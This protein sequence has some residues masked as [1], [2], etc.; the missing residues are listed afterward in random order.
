MFKFSCKTFTGTLPQQ[1]FAAGSLAYLG[2]YFIWCGYIA[3]I[4]LCLHPGLYIGKYL[5]PMSVGGKYMK[6]RREIGGK[7]KRTRKKEERKRKRG[8]KNLKRGSKRLK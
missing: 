3:W 5:P 7:C 6:R 2:T 1:S 4:L 8:E